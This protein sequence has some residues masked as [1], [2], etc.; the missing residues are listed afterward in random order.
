[1]RIVIW[2]IE[3]SPL[4]VPVWDLWNQTISHDVILEDTNILCACWKEL[5][6]AEVHNVRVDP[7]NPRDDRELCKVLYEALVTADVLVA[8]NGDDFDLRIF[9]S[10]LL[11]HG[12]HPLPPIKTVDTKKVAKSKFRFTSMKL[13]YLAKKLG[14][15][16]KKRTGFKL[17]L[18][19]LAGDEKALDYMVR[20]CAQ[21]IKLLEKVYLKMRPWMTNHPNQRLFGAINGCPNCG[22]SGTLVKD[23]KRYNQVTVVQ[24]YRCKAC[25]TW[26]S[27]TAM[28]SRTNVK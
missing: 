8:H 16:G 24:R 15:G 12:L 25:G 27:G 17:W 11:Y 26:P 28:I 13:D 22:K 9:N 6:K 1:M 20:Y 3:T 23:G 14:I 21:D 19:V 5:G 7:E 2:D 10:R 4:L 18:D